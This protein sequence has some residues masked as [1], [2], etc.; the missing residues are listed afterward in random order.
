M[1]VIVV[2]IKVSR[3]LLSMLLTKSITQSGADVPFDMQKV[4]ES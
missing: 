3:L 1:Q 4:A 2:R